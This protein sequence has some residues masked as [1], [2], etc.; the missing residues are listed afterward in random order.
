M[1]ATKSKRSLE[2][3]YPQWREVV[4]SDGSWTRIRKQILP[5]G[6]M[7]SVMFDVT[8]TK[9]KEKKL[10]QARL[11][12]DAS[13]RSKT[14]FL[15]NMSH[16]LRTPLNAVIGYSQAL[17]TGIFGPMANEKQRDYLETIEISGTHLLELINDILDISAVEVGKVVLKEENVVIAEAVNFAHQIVKTR[18]VNNGVKLS[19]LT[20]DAK[21]KVRGDGRRLRQIL[22]NLLSNAVK[23]TLEGGN[24]VVETRLN[25]DGSL[26]LSVSDTGLGMTQDEVAKA[27]EKFGQIDHQLTMTREGTGLGLPL[28]KELVEAHDGRLEIESQRGV[29]TKINIYLPKERVIIP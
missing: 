24:V 9:D 5:D 19:D 7:I 21:V 13:N 8:D 29:G 15:A 25:E 6:S 20:R 18:A 17:R 10:E 2:S 23:F 4:L 26:I 16:E 28:A 22:V 14:E 1:Q 3:T 12:S 11:A 27:M